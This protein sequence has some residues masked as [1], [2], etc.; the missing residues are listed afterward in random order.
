MTDL[1]SLLRRSEIMRNIKGKNTAPEILIRSLLHR[2]GY[3]FRLHAK[4][5]P[6]HPD[7]VSRSTA[8]QEAST[9]ILLPINALLVTH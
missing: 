8:D 7:T 9:S 3:R 2:M 6:G 1:V 4:E 5:L